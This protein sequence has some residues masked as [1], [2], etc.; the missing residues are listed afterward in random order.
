VKL[1]KKQ[2]EQ[3]KKQLLQH[4]RPTLEAKMVLDAKTTLTLTIQKGVVG[5]DIMSSGI[6]LAK[7]LYK[8]KNIYQKKICLDMGCGPGTQ[9]LIMAKYGAT[10]VLCTDISPLAIK[11]TQENA[12]KMKLH[13]HA[14]VSDLFKNIPK[15][16]FD[17]IVFNHPFFPEEAENFGDE[18]TKDVMLRKSMLGGTTLIHDFLKDVSSY[19][20]KNG[21]L[22]MPFFRFAGKENDPG[23]YAKKYKLKIVK[24]EKVLSKQGLQKGDFSIYVFSW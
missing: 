24:K 23:R 15:Q 11:N 7:F 17:V 9:G 2:Q 13:V 3:I 12:K 6:Y 4:Q 19:L 8:H 18:I 16:K 20:K 10:G 22:I 5:S 1:T 14:S 21:V